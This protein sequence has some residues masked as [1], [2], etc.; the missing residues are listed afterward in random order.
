MYF[1][2]IK[3]LDKVEQ[4]GNVDFVN[5][6]PKAIGGQ[7]ILLT[8]KNICQ[9]YGELKIVWVSYYEEMKTIRKTLLSCCNF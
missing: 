9:Q 6:I 5:L 8:L 4:R 2:C 7:S 1:E 3:I